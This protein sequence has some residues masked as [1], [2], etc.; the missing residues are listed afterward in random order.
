MIERDVIVQLHEG[1]HARPAALFAKLAKSFDAEIEVVKGERV[2]NAKSV[3]KLMLLAV[4]QGERI[5]LRAQGS[6]AQA[7]LD[8]LDDLVSEKPRSEGDSGDAKTLQGACGNAGT[9]VGPAFVHLPDTAAPVACFLPADAVPAEAE[10][11]RRAVA[12]VRASYLTQAAQAREPTEREILQALCELADDAALLDAALD[13]VAHGQ[14]AAS[15]VH[16]VGTE[17]AGQFAAAESDYFRARAQDMRDV[18]RHLA[19]ALLG[20][21]GHDL[22]QIAA[23]CIL[24]AADLGAVEF[25][26]LPKQHLLGL[27]L[28]DGGPT[29]HVAIM[30]RAFGLPLVLLPDADRELLRAA[31]FVAL[32]GAAGQAILDPDPGTCARFEQAMRDAAAARA[33][34]SHLAGTAPRTRAGRM[35]EVAANIGSAA[36][37]EIARRHGAM[38][39]GLFRTELLFMQGRRLPTEDEQYDIY[40][41]VLEGMAP[42]PVVIRTLDVGGDKPL[43]G[44][45]VEPEENP[46]LGWRGIRLCLDRPDLFKPQLRALLRA[47][48]HGRLRVML[49]MVSDVGEVR[50]ARAVLDECAAELGAEGAAVGRFDLGIMVETPAA[51]LC[52]EELAAEAAFFS[53]GTNDLTQY[54]M[55]ADRTHR[56]LGHLNR[57]DHPAVLRMIRMTCEAAAGRGVPVAVCGEMAADPALIPQLV[58]WGVSELS[59]SAPSIPRAKQ[60][61]MQL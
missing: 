47:A 44:L 21:G 43:P 12:D 9:V 40:R 35:V 38:G 45:P 39:V 24:V 4:Q 26:R 5:R 33:S 49:P 18:A 16:E 61:V 6:E 50:A 58:G 8:R 53:I 46:F 51:A 54:V 52:A 28:L 11:L 29:S 17:L 7:A 30:A 31:R 41:A 48:A 25:A 20:R 37:V 3:A 10:R 22:G 55:A 2:A 36:E 15:A 23:D 19:D 59:M 27:L 57:P 14:D 60:V 56:R 32:D 34:L 1:L 13:R 42:H